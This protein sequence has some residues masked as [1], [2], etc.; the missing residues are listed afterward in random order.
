M[1]PQHI[2][3]IGAGTMGHGIAQ[4]FALAG[5]AVTLTDNNAEILQKAIPRI[6]DNLQTYV[7]YGFA[8]LDEAEAVPSRITT[9]SNVPG[10]VAQADF[11][12]EAVFED[13]TIKHQILPVIEASCPPHAI[14]ASN[15]SS[16]RVGDMARV[17]NRPEQFLGNHW[18]NPPHLVPLVEV[19]YGE[20]T[21]PET[22]ET[23]R[24]LLKVVGKYPAL[25]RKDV[26]GFVGNRL[27][28]ALRREAIAL[29][30]QGVATPEDIDL[31]ARLS[32]GLRL[33]LIGPL[34]TVDLGGL[35]L[36]VSIQNYLLADLDRSIEP[37][38]FMRDKVASGELGAK[39][40]KGF[41]EWPPGRQ[42]EVIRKR[43][44]A[45][46]GLVKWLTDGGYIPSSA[47]D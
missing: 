38:Q 47:D 36:T 3:V 32:F 7:A 16:F 21:S 45:V 24:T 27:Q 22:I 6:K 9:V 19:I 17:L 2:A 28:H 35:D 18:W 26:A 41:F 43:D 23:T 29:V 11:I 8:T 44:Q 4:V 39:A 30:A 10:A 12:V 31:I 46:L 14:I 13:M 15:S 20:Q 37:S 5:Y 25:V 34:E 42:A 40:G 33:P 1:N